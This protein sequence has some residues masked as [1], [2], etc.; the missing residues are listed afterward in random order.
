MDD[1]LYKRSQDLIKKECCNY[2]PEECASLGEK[3]PMMGLEKDIAGNPLYKMCSWFKNY[4]VV[5][6]DK[7]LHDILSNSSSDDFESREC[8][9]CGKMFVVTDGRQTTCATCRTM[10]A[11]LKGIVKR[12][13]KIA[14]R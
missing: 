6:D 4:V 13:K 10:D 14:K 12:R 3:C 8:T 1:K 7:L 9:I 11:K 5:R 2:F